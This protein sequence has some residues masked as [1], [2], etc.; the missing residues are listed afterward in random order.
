MF[1][2]LVINPFLELR[3]TRGCGSS[4]TAHS[5]QLTLP[6]LHIMP[7][8]IGLCCRFSP[9]SEHGANAGLAVARDL[10]EPIKA[11]HPWISYADL[12]TLA[13]AVAIEAMGGAAAADRIVCQ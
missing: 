12:W 13:G 10:L 6:L 8:A 4:S 11:A 3:A 9:E 7:A 1:T 5:Q 2:Q